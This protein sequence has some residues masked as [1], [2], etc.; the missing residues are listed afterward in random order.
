MRAQNPLPAYN[1]GSPLRI[2][3]QA[4]NSAPA[5]ADSEAHKIEQDGV[6]YLW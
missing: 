5:K 1:G 6:V 3:E 2:L 4:S